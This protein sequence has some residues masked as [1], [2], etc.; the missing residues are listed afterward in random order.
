MKRTDDCPF[1]ELLRAALPSLYDRPPCR[2]RGRP[3]RLLSFS[4]NGK[5]LLGHWLAVRR[6]DLC[7]EQL[8]KEAEIANLVTHVR[9]L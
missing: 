3:T 6:C 1:P 2:R 4:R 7:A 5:S 9:K 8:R